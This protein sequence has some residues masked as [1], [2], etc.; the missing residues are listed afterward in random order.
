[1]PM[2]LEIGIAD[3]VVLVGAA[4]VVVHVLA[5]FALVLVVLVSVV[6]VRGLVVVCVLAAFMLVLVVLVSV[7]LVGGGAGDVADVGIDLFVLLAL[8]NVGCWWWQWWWH[9]HQFMLVFALTHSF[10]GVLVVCLFVARLIHIG[11]GV[12]PVVED[13]M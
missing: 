7:V 9:L 12:G 10:Y 5:A 2:M 4:L 1:M 6:L 13:A 8:G 11:V 3:K